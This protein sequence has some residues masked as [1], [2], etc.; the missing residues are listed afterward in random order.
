MMDGSAKFH[1]NQI[2]GTTGC[3]NG[4]SESDQY[5]WQ[6]SVRLIRKTSHGPAISERS[7]LLI[8]ITKVIMMYSMDSWQISVRLIRYVRKTSHGP[9]IS[10][11]SW[12][13]IP[14]T[15]AIT[16]YTWQLTKRI[17]TMT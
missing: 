2:Y 7:W 1:S 4:S 3:H 15:K 12:L 13:P 9:A 5:S 8:P 17:A 10:E 11:R 6:M 16:M 14:I